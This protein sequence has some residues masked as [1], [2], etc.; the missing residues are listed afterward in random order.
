VNQVLQTYNCSNCLSLASSSTI[1]TCAS[2]G[3]SFCQICTSR[4]AITKL[5]SKSPLIIN[6]GCFN[7]I[8]QNHLMKYINDKGLTLTGVYENALTNLEDK[9]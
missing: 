8:E 9:K 4:G 2:C 7:A 1:P 5:Q 6:P 3:K